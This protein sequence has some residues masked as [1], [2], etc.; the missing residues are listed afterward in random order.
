MD[1][2]LT[3]K[4]AQKLFILICMQNEN[5]AGISDD[6]SKPRNIL[7]KILEHVDEWNLRIS[8]VHINLMYIYACRD[9]K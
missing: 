6:L 5:L 9:G 2:M 4:E 1:E 8:M 3:S 7:T